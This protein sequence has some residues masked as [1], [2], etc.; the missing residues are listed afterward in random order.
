MLRSL[1]A[2]GASLGLSILAALLPA[3][4]TPA[5]PTPADPSVADQV[6][7]L[8][9]I[10]DY[11]AADYPAAVRGRQIASSLEYQ[12]QLNFLTDADAL[13]AGLPAVDRPP[14][15]LRE[16]IAALRDLIEQ[17]APGEQVATRARAA[18]S[19]LLAHYGVVLAPSAPPSF[20]RGRALYAESCV[21]CHGPDGRGNGVLAPT[22]TPA[23]RSFHDLEVMAD[24][25]PAR[26]FS[27]LTDGLDGTAMTSFGSLSA[28][29][30]WS[31]AFYVFTLRHEPSAI[32]RG[33]L[34]YEQSG[35]AVAATPTRLAG[36]SDAEIDRALAGTGLN[37]E[38]RASALA[39]L[40]GSA[41]YRTTGAPFDP[42]RELLA[43]ALAS[44]HAGDP[45]AARRQLSAAYLDGFEPHEAALALHDP[46]LVTGIEQAFL[47]TRAALENGVGFAAAEQR[48]LRIGALLDSGEERLAGS[49]SNRVAFVGSLVILLREG[50]EGALLVLLLLGWARQAGADGRDARA[51]QRGW[52]AALALGAVTW[53]AAGS[54][55]GWL[56]GARR[57]LI[58][59]VVALAAAVVLLA[60]SHFVLAQLNARR[61]VERLR[62][63]LDA[64]VSPARRRV[65]LA[66]L[67][68][69]AVYR[70]AFE[71][72]L[73]L[74]ALM[75]DAGSSGLAIAAGAGTGVTLLVVLVIFGRRVGS[76]LAPNRVLRASGA[77]LCAL[78]VVLAGKGIR[79]LQEAGLASIHALGSPRID[80][81]GVYPTVETLAAQGIA[82]TVF[83]AIALWAYASARAG[84]K[85]DS[86]ASDRAPA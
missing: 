82:I 60:A 13:A 32:E 46:E 17:L 58:E 20:E 23:P 19:Q 79:S 29:E 24:L 14:L 12:E 66:S 48:V 69:V 2:L 18:R 59:G 62:R 84:T 71:V 73:F 70:E 52:I 47:D 45:A 65:V 85:V 16:Q 75:L 86:P 27:A 21:A 28:S 33:D 76:S 81:L 41:P 54:L 10:L 78:A 15:E 6:R 51:V 83:A 26:A 30:R 55:L 53:V 68:F 67:A 34:A 43:R 44:Y 56:G 61:R 64:A 4:D 80:W 38:E 77:L 5:P 37:A 63:R 57:E 39:F 36:A 35:R 72:V 3:C 8:A 40:R 42:T 50:L 1:R 49:G 22:L 25:T 9:A 74:R 11:V 31:L 7:Q